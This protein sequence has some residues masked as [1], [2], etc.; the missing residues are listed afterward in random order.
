MTHDDGTPKSMGNAFTRHLWDKSPSI[1]VA[2]QPAVKNA[3]NTTA[4]IESE[5]EKGRDI[6]AVPGMGA[7]WTTPAKEAWKKTRLK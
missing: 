7:D 4:Y 3:A 2:F 1:A 6:R 5:R